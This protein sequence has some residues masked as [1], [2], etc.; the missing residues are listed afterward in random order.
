MMFRAS[1]FLVGQGVQGVFGL[2]VVQQIRQELDG[3]FVYTLEGV[4]GWWREEF[5]ACL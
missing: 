3:T 2:A 5:L 4:E 1:P